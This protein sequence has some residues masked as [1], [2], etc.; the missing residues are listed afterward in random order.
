[1]KNIILGARLNLPDFQHG[2]QVLSLEDKTLT[3]AWEDSAKE[4]GYETHIV[5]VTKEDSLPE[6]NLG[7]NK[8]FALLEYLKEHRQEIDKVCVADTLDVIFLKPNLFD[9]IE[10]NTIYIG[11]EPCNLGISWISINSYPFLVQ[12]KFARWFNGNSHLSLLNTGLIAGKVDIVIDIMQQMTD[13]LK[14][15]TKGIDLGCDMFCLNYVAYRSTYKIVQGSP[16]NTVFKSYDY[17]NKEC[18]AAHK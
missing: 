6:Y 5:Q 14:S 18:Y 9:Y 4:N 17:L 13:L 8:C 1:M 3:Q 10:D 7:A 15:F 2:G 11:N 12:E 16:F